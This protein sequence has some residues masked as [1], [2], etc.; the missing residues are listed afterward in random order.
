MTTPAPGAGNRRLPAEPPT[1]TGELQAT[2]KPQWIFAIALGSAVGWGA[3]ILPVDWLTSGGT[4]GALIGMAVGGLLITVIALSYGLVIKKFPVTGG[5]LAYA[6]V[7]MGR[8]HAFVAGWFLALGYISIVAL[9]A[10]ALALVV[11]RTFPALMQQGHLWTVAGWDIYLPEVLLSL[12]ALI[13]FAIFN[14]RATALSG[15]FQYIA[16][17]IMLSAGGLILLLTVVKYVQNPVPL[18]QSFPTG[19]PPWA[20]I[21]MIVALAPWAFVG[22]DNVPQLAGEFNFSPKRAL[23]LIVAAIGTSTA[24]YLAMIMATSIAVSE[25]GSTFPDSAWATAE[26]IRAA[27]GPIGPVLLVIAVLTGVVT[28]LNGFM[29]SASR[30]LMAMA[31]ARMLPHQLSLVSLKHNTPVAAMVFVLLFCAVTPFFGRAALSWIVDMT[32]AG[33]TVAYFY[34]CLCAYQAVKRSD[35]A[36]TRLYGAKLAIAITGCVLA[37]IF[38]A[39]L[40]IPGSPGALELPSLVAFVLWVVLGIV[41]Y[42]LR[43]RALAAT[44]DAEMHDLILGEHAHKMHT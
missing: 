22:F 24:F 2:F 41:F 38:L 18:Y 34:T 17:L 39:L 10:S 11:R 30:L 26:A 9:N 36:T 21:L 42:L 13:G 7:A 29:V 20:A 3:F 40:F 12:A 16:C 31:N 19:E 37:V 8:R 33:V 44:S 28:G 43:R 32:S 14:A 6:Y 5:E 4:A 15:Q 35:R 23:W 27:I 1:E 25:A